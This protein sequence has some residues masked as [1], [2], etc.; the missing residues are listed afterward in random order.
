[1]KIYSDTKLDYDDILI[2]PKITELNSR[3]EVNLEVSYTVKNKYIYGVPLCIANMGTTG[4]F[5]IAKKLYQYKIFTALHKYYTIQEIM[6]FLKNKNA[7]KIFEYTWLTMGT[8]EKDY[9]KIIALYNLIERNHSNMKDDYYLPFPKLL[10]IDIANGYQKSFI[11][12]IKKIKEKLIK[13]NSNL[14]DM[15][16]CCG[17]VV[18]PDMAVELVKAGADIIK[19]GLGSGA[20]CTTRLQSGIG[21]PQLSAIMECQQDIH[22]HGGLLMADGGIKN[23]GDAV[24]AFAAGADFVMAGSYFAGTNECQGTWEKIDGDT[25]LTHYGMASKYAMKKYYTDLKSYRASEGKVVRVKAKGKIDDLIKEF[26]GGMRSGCS[27]TNSKNLK[28]LKINAEFIKVN[29]QINNFFKT[30]FK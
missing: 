30:N 7:C 9:N 6:D 4:T 2:I 18:T 11:N 10:M 19:V 5:E 28:D 21:Y 20:V 12:F 26:M 3:A 13:I 29:N 1:M 16:I 15:V 25:Y 17:N 23:P 24:K 22:D 14:Q 27:Y 8:S